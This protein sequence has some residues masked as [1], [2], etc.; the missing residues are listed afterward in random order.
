MKK[1]YILFTYPNQYHVNV[2]HSEKQVIVAEEGDQHLL[3]KTAQQLKDDNLFGNFQLVST[4][5]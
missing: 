4:I 5:D 1:Y 2:M 3:V